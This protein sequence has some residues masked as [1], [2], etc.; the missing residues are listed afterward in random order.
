MDLKRK[1]SVKLIVQFFKFG[2]VGASNTAISYI[3]YALTL[4]IIG[5]FGKVRWDYFA[6]NTLSFLLSV[7]W[8]FYFNNR[9]VFSKDKPHT[10]KEILKILLKTYI[11]YGFT[12][13]I[14]NNLLS[15]LW[16]DVLGVS[17]YLAMLPN[18]VISIPI[19]FIL[20]K[21]WAFGDKQ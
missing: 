7:L 12:G 2:I 15:I 14:L 8:S 10:K 16:I 4:F 21:L 1:F 11:A 5:L 18:L 20:V 6:A 19:N 9:F 13:L 3:V 17:K